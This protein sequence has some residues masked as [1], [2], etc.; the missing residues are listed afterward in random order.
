LG[1]RLESR[2]E[3]VWFHPPERPLP[4][5]EL[6]FVYDEGSIWLNRI[7]DIYRAGMKKWGGEVIMGMTDLGGAMDI[8]T[9]FCGGENLLIALYDD[10][11]GV[12][13]CIGELQKLWFRF[14]DEINGILACSRGYTDWAGIYS[15][16]PSY[17]QQS[18]FSYM[19][20]ADMFAEFV[21]PELDSSAA[22]LHKSFYHLDGEGQLPHLKSLLASKHIAGI[23]W[24][25]GAGEPRKKDWSGLFKTVSAAGKK[26]QGVYGGFDGY[27][28]GLLA[29]VE[30]PDDVCNA[31]TCCPITE[32]AQ[33]LKKLEGLGIL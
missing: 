32:K 22:R 1:A 3:T 8:L 10:P 17:M 14:F 31:D 5:S 16:K 7:K 20:S 9:T 30:R 21:M 2:S 26:L 29:S 25:P 23:Q 19:I 13:R 18:D 15:E 4:P 27:F 33:T 28:Q 6:E 24:V 11:G 12:K